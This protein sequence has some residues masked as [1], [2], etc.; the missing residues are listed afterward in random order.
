[1]GSYLRLPVGYEV[2]FSDDGS[3]LLCLGIRIALFDISKR[4][5][6][7]VGRQLKHP[8]HGGFSPDGLT[9]AVKNTSGR[10]VILETRSG[11]LLQDFKNQ[12]EG[13][14]C[15]V[16][17]SP[18]GKE[19]V[20]GAWGDLLTVRNAKNGA[21]KSREEFPGDM[22]RRI[23][24]DKK[25]RVWLIE[26]CP[27]WS[28]EKPRNV[29]TIGYVRLRR[30]PITAKDEHV[31]DLPVDVLQATLHPDG[32]TFCFTETAPI[33]HLYVAR[34]SDGSILAKSAPLVQ[35]RIRDMAWFPSGEI[36]ASVQK[37]KFVFYRSSDLAVLGE[38]PAKYPSSVAF[39]PGTQDV[40][41]GTWNESAIVLISDV[42]TGR[43]SLFKEK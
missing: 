36:I 13:E 3:L 20:D 24:H 25:R 23:S 31:L 18:D 15:E 34:V 28:P 14:G 7:W 4:E 9:V 33:A 37:G 38:V 32:K 40:A 8:S 2:R 12:K 29:P 10:I 22:P 42:L 1:M 17:F 5:R 30:W 39:R 6:L 16:Y 35:D 11:E 19:I 27:R 43:V 41:L 26:H 21:I